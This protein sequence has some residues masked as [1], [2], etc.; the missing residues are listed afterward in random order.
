MIVEELFTN[1]IAHGHGGD[2]ANRVIVNLQLDGDQL[3]LRYRDRGR[4]FDTTS[5]VGVPPPG[6][7][8]GGLGIGLVHALTSAMTY[9]R[10]DDWNITELSL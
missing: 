5:I 1:T 6:R 3:L 9:R 4:P 8:I 2:S 10:D 7:R